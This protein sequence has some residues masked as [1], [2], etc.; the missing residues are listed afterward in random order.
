MLNASDPTELRKNATILLA[1]AMASA[2]A[3]L[4]CDAQLLIYVEEH[5]SKI[6]AMACNSHYWTTAVTEAYGLCLA[7]PIDEWPGEFLGSG[8]SGSSGS[9]SSSDSDSDSW[10]SSD[11][12]S[13]SDS[14]DWNSSSSDSDSDSDSWGSSDSGSWGGSDSD[15]DSDSWDW[16]SSSS[17]SDSD[18]DSW[19]GSDSDSGSNQWSWPVLRDGR[20][21]NQDRKAARKTAHRRLL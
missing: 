20:Q 2:N 5:N 17:D 6:N 1:H 13:D 21:A 4:A 15:S 3:S 11:S 9:S 16:H 7:C 14:W 10:G 8:S 18:S 12:N 19:G